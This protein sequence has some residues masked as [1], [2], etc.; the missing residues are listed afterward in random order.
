M[1]GNTFG[2]LLRLT[3]FGESHGLAIGGILDGFPPGIHIDEKAVQHQLNRRRPGQSEIVTPR[4]EEDQ[5]EILS[6]IF[7]GKSTGAPIGFSI[8]NKQ[9]QSADYEHLKDVFRPGHAD[10]TYEK[11]YGIRDYRGGGRS[12]ARET[13]VRVAAGALAAQILPNVK[14][15][16][17][18]SQVGPITLGG[19]PGVYSEKEIEQS[20]VRCPDPSLAKK[21]I[22]YIEDLR[23]KGDSIG[24]IISCVISGV[25]AGWGEPVFDKLNAD[26]AKAML[27]INAVKG[28][29]MGSGFASAAM[30]GSE[31]NDSFTSGFQTSSNHSG[32][33]Q[34]GISNGQDIVFRVAF[35][36][37]STI[38]KA[39]NT[40]NQ[41]RE[42]VVLE[43]YGRHDP[44]VVPRAV[45][46]VDAMAYLVLAD[47][48]LR[49]RVYQK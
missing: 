31:C 45:P 37:V 3:T 11:K 48:F 7:E 32:G 36:P 44:C 17:Y 41:Q 1:A 26:L 29:E 9:H 42:E 28:F 15:T 18:V 14:V 33:I 2:T 47:H 13:A 46:I 25:P 23:D 6:G 49:Q 8:R 20:I 19:A 27:S 24:G 38:K 30:L 16:S 4:S 35:K 21:M 40:L 39:Q 34:G 10:F 5:I 22:E 43:A 12:S